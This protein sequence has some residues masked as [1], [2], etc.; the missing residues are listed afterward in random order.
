MS[1]ARF[2]SLENKK[3]G[4]LGLGIENIELINRILET[5]L[6]C[7]I[8]ICDGRGKEDLGEKFKVLSKRKRISWRIGEHFSQNLDGFDIVFRSPGWP[9]FDPEIA[10]AIKLG[11]IVTSPI[12]YF[13]ELCPSKNIIGVTG[14]KGKGT[15]A[16]LIYAIIEKSGHKVWLGGNIG[17]APFGFLDKIK[18]NDYVILELSSFQLEDADVSPHVAVI[19]NFSREHQKAAD[20]FNPNHHK[21]MV[22]YWHAKANIFRWQKKG[23]RAFLNIKLKNKKL[24]AGKGKKVF[25]RK[26]ELKTKL[27]GKHNM[28]NIAAAIEVAK[29]LRIPKKTIESAIADFKG[30][31]HRIEFV[32]EIEEVRYYN[33][34]FATIPE[35]T[36]TALRAFKKPIIL[37]AGGSDKGSNFK[38]LSYHIKKRVKFLILIK[39]AALPRIM[40][41]LEEIAY[42]KKNLETVESMREAVRHAYKQAAKNEIVLLSPAC[43][44]FGVFKNYK[45]RGELF[46][47]AVNKL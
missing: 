46:K 12:R 4:I 10:K 22:S 23:D 33:D 35:S 1:K 30:L 28:E 18:K 32:R 8:T 20:P 13:L 41:E 17:V 21:S 6:H 7:T 34:S 5:K 39:G 11:T 25:F 43:A 31:E 44:S 3:I 40:A 38:E 14:T 19:T 47:E 26:S 45:E 16:S 9:Y 2:K 27:P 36:I 42:N 15:T 24:S 37:I 29:F